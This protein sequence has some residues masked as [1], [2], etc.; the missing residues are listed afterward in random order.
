MI[1]IEEQVRRQAQAAQAAARKVASLSAPQKNAALEAMARALERRCQEILAA[2]AEDV[3]SAR[4]SGLS[5][6]LID[7]LTLSEGRVADMVEGLRAGIRTA[8]AATG[9]VRS[10]GGAIH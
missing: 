9:D 2:N 3:Q 10:G 1:S 7:R 8:L 4:A 6:A 5:S